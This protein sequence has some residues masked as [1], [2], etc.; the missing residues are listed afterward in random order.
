VTS[1]QQRRDALEVAIARGGGIIA[2]AKAMGVTHQAVT[3][4]RKKSC[5][6]L[7][8]AMV[9][10]HLYG[11]GREHIIDPAIAEALMAPSAASV[12]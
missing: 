3:F 2:F 7:P 4:W 10:E 6:P 5:V 11:V 8:R 12:L 9:I 1:P